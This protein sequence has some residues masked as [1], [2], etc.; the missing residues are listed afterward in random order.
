MPLT[1]RLRE[2]T[3]R[4]VQGREGIVGGVGGESK[5]GFNGVAGPERPTAGP[6]LIVE[7]VVDRGGAGGEVLQE[8]GEPGVKGSPGEEGVGSGRSGLLEEVDGDVG[9]EGEDVDRGVFLAGSV[10]GWAGPIGGGTGAR[11][12]LAN[13]ADEV[14]NVR[15]GL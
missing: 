3:A 7:V 15:S 9:A 12:E 1:Q 4:P 2:R 13:A 14:K 8:L 6:G 11:L 10:W 5:P